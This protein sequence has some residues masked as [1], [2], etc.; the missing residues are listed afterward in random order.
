[1][2]NDDRE[3]DAKYVIKQYECVSYSEKD[4]NRYA[5]YARNDKHFLHSPQEMA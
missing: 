2:T 3:N 1:M 5:H 4:T